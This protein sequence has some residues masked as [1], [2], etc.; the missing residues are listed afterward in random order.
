MASCVALQK[1]N[2]VGVSPFPSCGSSQNGPRCKGFAAPRRNGAPLTAPGR[3]EE[4]L[5]EMRERRLW[6][7]YDPGISTSRRFTGETTRALYASRNLHSSRGAGCRKL[8]RLPA[9]GRAFS[10][11]I[12]FYRTGR[13][14]IR[15]RL[16]TQI[17]LTSKFSW[18]FGSIKEDVK[19]KSSCASW[20]PQKVSASSPVPLCRCLEAYRAYVGEMFR[21]RGHIPNP[22]FPLIR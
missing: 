15:K 4:T 16:G 13:S 12:L 9:R 11:D 8:S 17:F 3:S 14:S 20:K 7:T 5:P 6:E 21:C 19:R 22:P 2:R 10:L 1:S 18:L